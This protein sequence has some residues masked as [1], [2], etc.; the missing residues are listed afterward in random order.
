MHRKLIHNSYDCPKWLE[1][2]F[3]H[4]GVLIGLAGPIGM[5][6]THDLRDWAQRQTDSHPYF[7][8]RKPILI[9]AYWQLFCNITL[10]S[11]P[12]FLLEENIKSNAIYGWME[13]HWMAQQLPWAILLYICG[14]L[15][16]VIWGIFVR[17]AV[18]IIG[19]WLI[20]YFAHNRGVRNWHISGASVQGYNVKFCG[21]IS[22]GECWHNNHHAFPCSAKIGLKKG[23]FDPGWLVLTLLERLKL[24][25]NLTTPNNLSPRKEL[26][27]I[28]P[29]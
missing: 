26:E 10:K 29:T 3:V 14:G 13:K 4:L 11:P 18:S 9:D 22:M 16:W 15:A 1:Y 7:G 28:I 21:L 19:H 24:V 25:S 5:I 8:H 23:E 12:K 17:A 20:G 27:S 6:K 2:F